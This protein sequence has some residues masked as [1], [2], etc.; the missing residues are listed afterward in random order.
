MDPVT[1]TLVGA[2][3]A[4][5]G[6]KRRTRLAGATLLIGANLPDV[7]VV[8]LMWTPETGLWFRRGVTHGFLAMALLPFILTGAM[9]LLDRLGTW[10]KGREPPMRVRPMQILILATLAIASHPVLDSLNV[11]G[12]RWLMPFSGSWFYG[13]TLFIVDPWVWGFL[14]AG[15]YLARKWDKGKAS[16]WRE[17]VNSERGSGRP[18]AVSLLV[19]AVYIALMAG[20]NLVA[21]GI[22]R[23]AAAEQGIVVRKLMVAPLPINPFVRSVVLEDESSYRMGTF[24]WFSRPRFVL[25]D[26]SWPNYPSQPVEAAAVRGPKPRRF[27]AWARFPFFVTEDVGDTAVVRIMD[28]RYTTDPR[29]VW[30]VTTV[31]IGR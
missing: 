2:A 3:L 20:S 15:V 10:K 28:L 11:Y 21:R 4:E 30:A 6:L 27:M 18:A 14:G 19:A 7:D 1:H 22:V 25:I 5:S 31:R 26:S 9:L 13:D 24:N 17:A 23:G 12:M 16:G 29:A 8:S